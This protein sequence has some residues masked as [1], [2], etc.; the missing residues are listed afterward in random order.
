VSEPGAVRPSQR[1]SVV[2][3][4]LVVAGWAAWSLWSGGIVRTLV[5]AAGDPA[6]SI[7]ILRAQLAR[8]G[9]FGPLVYIAAVVIEV[10]VAPIPGTLLY[11]PAGAIFGGLAGGTYSLAGNVLGAMTAT[12]IARAFGSR[13]TDRL[14]HSA[15]ETYVVRVRERGLLIVALLRLNPLTSSDLVSYAAGLVGIPSWRVGVATLVGM[16]PLCY[17]QAYAAE[18]IFRV[19]PGSGVVLLGLG[20]AYVAVILVLVLR[21]KNR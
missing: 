1:T 18:R 5:S 6:G 15:L 11:A 3:V 8:A 9:P 16:A 10:V 14:E 7:D 20:I 21:R 19:L 13:I 12:F 17:L 2:I 4:L